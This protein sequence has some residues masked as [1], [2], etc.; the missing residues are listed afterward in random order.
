MASISKI[1][2]SVT[3]TV[4]PKDIRATQASLRNNLRDGWNIGKRYSRINDK[5]KP[6]ALFIKIKSSVRNIKV[7]TD[8]IP[9]AMAAGGFMT[10]FP[11]GSLCGYVL[12]HVVK[13]LI[14]LF[15]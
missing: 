3:K 11:G 14:K 5:N 1:V 2:S 12:G 7:K 8:D 4:L 10:P 15:K 6:Q 13:N 9:T